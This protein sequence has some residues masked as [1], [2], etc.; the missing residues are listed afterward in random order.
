MLNGDA[1]IFSGQVSSGFLF[2][3]SFSLSSSVYLCIFLI[4]SSFY[5]LTR[6]AISVT[7]KHIPPL[8]FNEYAHVGTSYILKSYSEIVLPFTFPV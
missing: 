3:Y 5:N 4:L 1:R 2:S 6:S 8:L 7:G